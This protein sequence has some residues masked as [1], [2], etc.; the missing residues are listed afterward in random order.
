M[1]QHEFL[2]NFCLADNQVVPNENPMRSISADAATRDV[3]AI[4]GSKGMAISA[5]LELATKAP[6]TANT[7]IEYTESSNE[8]A[9][10]IVRSE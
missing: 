3:S 10:G 5:P 4:S 8:C 1:Q 7:N 2:Q 6:E 9:S